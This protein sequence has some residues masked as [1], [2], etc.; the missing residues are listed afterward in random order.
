MPEADRKNISSKRLAGNNFTDYRQ[1]KK[2]FEEQTVLVSFASAGN[3]EAAGDIVL[4][5]SDLLEIK[6]YIAKYK[7]LRSSSRQ[8]VIKNLLK[9]SPY[10]TIG[11]FAGDFGRFT[12]SAYSANNQSGSAPSGGGGS[13]GSSGGR[14]SNQKMEVSGIKSDDELFPDLINNKRICSF[15]DIDGF[16]WAK[17]AIAGLY[18]DGV[19]DGVSEKSFMPGKEVKREEFLKMADRL[20]EGTGTN[21]LFS[22]ADKSAWYYGY[23]SKA[24][25]AGITKGVGDNIFGIGKSLTREDAAVMI[26]RMILAKEPEYTEIAFNDN[27]EISGYAKASIGYLKELGIMNGDENGNFNP[28]KPLRRAEAAVLISNVLKKIAN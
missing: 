12:D 6:D 3:I 7:S 16:E 5:Y 17:E 28:K 8:E 21:T 13:I 22:D 24:V 23:I 2:A 20:Y 15:A 18:E 1:I 27:E 19:I 26:A 14:G 4:T 11:K 25:G 10:E 9:A